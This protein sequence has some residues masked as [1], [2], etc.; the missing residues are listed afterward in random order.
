MAAKPLSV[1][2]SITAPTPEPDPVLDTYPGVY[3]QPRPRPWAWCPNGR[4]KGWDPVRRRFEQH[5]CDKNTCEGCAVRRA[6]KV[7]LALGAAAPAY[8]VT[9]TAA[10]NCWRDAN[11]R[12]SKFRKT[13]SKVSLFEAAY[14]VERAPGAPHVHVHVLWRG[15]LPRK[16][17]LSEIAQGAG[18]GWEVDV[19]DL[20]NVDGIAEYLTKQVRESLHEHLDLNGGWLIHATRKFWTI[21]GEVIPDGWKGVAKALN[22][23]DRPGEGV[24][25]TIVPQALRATP[26]PPEAHPIGAHLTTVDSRHIDPIIAGARAAAAA[27]PSMGTRL[28]A[29]TARMFGMAVAATTDQA[30]QAA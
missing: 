6:F 4:S 19:T 18:F 23:R 3:D 25:A 14:V 9:L 12:W 11:D 28:Q 29:D 15:N 13:I 20:W 10:G 7:Q 16:A 1:V 30:M 26:Q 5:P 21:D 2:P 22:R 24:I 27:A 17:V 8:M